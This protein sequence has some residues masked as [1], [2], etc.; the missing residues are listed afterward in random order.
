[1]S[2]RAG[3]PLPFGPP[4]PW[5]EIVLEP[6][7]AEATASL[8][9]R[10]LGDHPS[11]A[12]L[13]ARIAERSEGHPF[14]IEEMI[15]SLVAGRKVVGE[16]G[17][18]RAAGTVEELALPAT[19]SALLDARIDALGERERLVL[20]A[21]SVLGREFAAPVL[22]RVLALPA[23]ETRAA[24]QVL[25]DVGLLR[26][27]SGDDLGG[28]SFGH[29][30]VGLIERLTGTDPRLEEVYRFRH[31]LLQEVAYHSQLAQHRSRVHADVARTLERLDPKR[32]DERA[33]LI[34]HHSERAGD[35]I[36]A[37]HWYARAARWQG[38][39]D[40]AEAFRCW[41][42]VR[43]LC[44]EAEVTTESLA[45]L[46][47]AGI[48]AM[49]L[50][51][52][53]GVAEDEVEAIFEETR[54]G[55]ERSGRS[56]AVAGA[57]GAFAIVR[58]MAG[59][60][61]ESRTR[62]REA[63]RLAATAERPELEVALISA[64]AYAEASSGDL[65]AALATSEYGLSLGGLDVELG[66][67]LAFLRPVVFLTA[68]RGFVLTHQGKLDE[69][70][71]ALEQALSLSDPRRD[72]EVI[73]WI[74]GWKVLHARAT[75]N[76]DGALAD[77]R[78]GLE[79]AERSGSPF[80]QVIALAYLGRAH[81]LLS[82][83]PEAVA[84]LERSLLLARS[85]RTGLETEAAILADLALALLAHGDSARATRLANEATD[86]A[87]RRGLLLDEC[88]ANIAL[89]RVLLEGAGAPKRRPARKCLERALD[90]ARRIGARFLEAQVHLR[91]ADA[92]RRGGDEL[93]RVG[94]LS[95]AVAGFREIGA[96]GHAA[97]AAAELEGI[98]AGDAADAEGLV[99]G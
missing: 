70:G 40:P 64:L 18:Y 9:D 92:A 97:N 15:Q 75:G 14:F 76:R 90:L 48:Q 29:A 10:L 32:G 39:N 99:K 27:S 67:D 41:Q 8:V 49:N 11:V 60:V 77:A 47:R 87:R 6:L 21:A 16:E 1:L 74:S 28:R 52:R 2:R 31:A 7:S 34:A 36:A 53:I 81:A 12:D 38:S 45:L 25:C 63:T 82:E 24:L 80:S 44:R 61:V 71:R 89:A 59:H 93:T 94:E 51:W 57:L 17:D 86:V 19:F 22:E 54:A 50:S 98:S 26:G 84:A 23:E 62:L 95:L 65:Q 85:R 55:A 72:A 83:W 91:L 13:A 3:L 69:A 33:A 37:A 96:S 66:A 58:G 88:A 43:S 20:Q 5:R 35:S 56:D 30:L 4:A 46:V 42:K 79:I 78:R 68:L 73:G